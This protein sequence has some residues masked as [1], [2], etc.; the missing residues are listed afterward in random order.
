M[1]CVTLATTITLKLVLAG[2]DLLNSIPT[3]LPFRLTVTRLWVPTGLI[4][5]LS[6]IVDTWRAYEFACEYKEMG[7]YR[8]IRISNLGIP[9]QWHRLVK[10][11]RG[12]SYEKNW[13]FHQNLRK[14]KRTNKEQS[15]WYLNL[16]LPGMRYMLPAC[17]M[18]NTLG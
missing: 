14:E 7:R 3:Y 6:T 8:T 1:D 18:G 5:N 15:S 13:D 2:F 11:K 17:E 10:K 12:K 16:Y 4:V 9:V